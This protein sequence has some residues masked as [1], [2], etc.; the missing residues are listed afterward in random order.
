LTV[1]IT[2]AVANAAGSAQLL[3]D[4]AAVS[5]GVAGKTIKPIVVY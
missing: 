1:E 5:D 2:A 3:L 4:N